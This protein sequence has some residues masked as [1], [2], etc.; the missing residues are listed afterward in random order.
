ML[1]ARMVEL[2]DTLVSGTSAVRYTSSS[3]VPGNTKP[4][5][6]GWFFYFTFI[7]ILIQISIYNIALQRNMWL[8]GSERRFAL[9]LNVRYYYI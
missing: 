3:L 7:Y 4:V 2:V 6:A 8:H 1:S 5:F 9:K